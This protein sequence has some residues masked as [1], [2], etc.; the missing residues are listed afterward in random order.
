MVGAFAEERGDAKLELQFTS[1]ENTQRHE[2]YLGF[3]ITQSVGRMSEAE[4]QRSAQLELWR[5]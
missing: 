2:A 3:P 5:I 4:R 1:D